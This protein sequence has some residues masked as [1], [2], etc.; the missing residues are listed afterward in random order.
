MARPCR[1]PA[2][3]HRLGGCGRRGSFPTWGSPRGT[4][5]LAAAIPEPGR[6]ARTTRP[7]GMIVK[8]DLFGP[9]DALPVFQTRS[10]PSPVT[11]DTAYR[12]IADERCG[13]RA[14]A[15]N[16]PITFAGKAD[17]HGRRR[18]PR[19]G[20]TRSS[21]PFVH[22][23]A[24]PELAGRKLAVTFHIPGESGPMTW[25]ALAMTTSYV[26]A[27]ERRR[28]SANWKTTA[29][30]PYG[31]TSWFFL[32]AVDA[33][34]APGDEGAWCA[35]ATAPRRT[36][37]GSTLNGDDRWTDVLS[38]RLHAVDGMQRGRGERGA[39]RQPGARPAGSSEAGRITQ[40]REAPPPRRGW[41]GTCSACPGVSHVIW[42]E[43][44]GRPGRC[45]AP[46]PTQVRDGMAAA[47]AQMRARIKGVKV[48]GGDSD[49]HPR[50][51][52][53]GL[54]HRRCR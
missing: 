14:R 53:A 42:L 3:G 37:M 38:R 29:P 49:Q 12:R 40:A 23:P 20:A 36:A 7:S 44:Y 47:A 34:A 50:Q 10:A 9:A 46:R 5:S 54:W 51:C 6:Q 35:S 43:G 4:P 1:G 33:M 30:M 11:F 22:D 19:P 39:C 24:A 45:R 18:G 48:I 21:L 41:S 32:D 27:P 28:A 26:T 2:L 8:P 31:A 15:R 16:R 17:R 25:H 52:G 13:G